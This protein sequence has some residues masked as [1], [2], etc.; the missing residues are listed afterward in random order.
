LR[1]DARCEHAPAAFWQSQ[2]PS[3]PKHRAP[4]RSCEC[5]IYAF[6]SREDAETLAREK[7]DTAVLAVGRVSLW[8]H[9]VETE[10]GY[11]SQHAYPYDVALLGGSEQLARELRDRY[12]IDVTCAPAIAALHTGSG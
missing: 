8:G 12:A 10:R 2:R 4:A 6:K 1:L 7:A 9:V 5:G 3:E 11:R